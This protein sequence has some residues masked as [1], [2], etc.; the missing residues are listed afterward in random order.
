M[1]S[2]PDAM[3]RRS[4]S[5]TLRKADY[6]ALDAVYAYAAKGADPL[7]M[8]W[9]GY[10]VNKT[11]LARL[12]RIGYIDSRHSRCIYVKTRPDGR[13][14]VSSKPCTIYRITNAGIASVEARRAPEVS[15][16]KV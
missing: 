10:G 12:V 1:L 15:H 14:R 7:A 16:A 11:A 4:H 8:D 2:G 13:K 6:E 3:A 5:Y 9:N